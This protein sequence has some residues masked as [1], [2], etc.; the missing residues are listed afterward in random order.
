MDAEST[1][2]EAER[3]RAAQRDRPRCAPRLAAS[4]C[5]PNI[6]RRNANFGAGTVLSGRRPCPRAT[7][8]R[9]PR[10]WA[11]RRCNT[12]RR[13]EPRGGDPGAARGSQ[14]RL[15]H[16]QDGV[17]G[18]AGIQAGDPGRPG[19][20]FRLRRRE[21]RFPVPHC[22]VIFAEDAPRTRIGGGWGRQRKEYT[23]FWLSRR[24]RGGQSD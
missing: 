8:G 11:R 20:L 13:R 16:G 10:R 5:V 21:G 24:G 17:R 7:L 22:H 12:N 3:R 4:P 6:S 1:Q 19:G 9:W 15:E 23:A 14:S 18:Q 2:S